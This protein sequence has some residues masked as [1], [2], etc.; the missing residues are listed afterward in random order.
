MLLK[1]W[2]QRRRR[3][4]SKKAQQDCGGEGCRPMFLLQCLWWETGVPDRSR[5][6]ITSPFT[7]ITN[8][9]CSSPHR[10]FLVTPSAFLS[11]NWPCRLL[12]TTTTP[13]PCTLT[14]PA[15]HSSVL[16]A[17]S[18]SWQLLCGWVSRCRRAQMQTWELY[19]IDKRA[20]T[21]PASSSSRCKHRTRGMITT[22]STRLPCTENSNRILLFIKK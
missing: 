19:I 7:I 1:P 5:F 22:Y 3:K 18:V 14:R 4:K 21:V 11:F 8:A 12:R 17:H 2:D 10:P 9:Y 20:W 16:R 6:V 13:Y 15:G